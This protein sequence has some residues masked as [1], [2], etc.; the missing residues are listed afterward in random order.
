[1][2]DFDKNLL[3]FLES[4]QEQNRPI[5]LVTGVFDLLHSGH[6]IFLQKAKQKMRQL[7][8]YLLVGLESDFRV[9][10]LKGN[11]R[12]INNQQVRKKELADLGLV[13]LV[14]LLPDEFGQ[15]QVR[16]D[17]LK[18]IKPT[19][20]LVSSSTPNI[21]KKVQMIEKVGGKLKIIC[22]HYPQYSTTNIINKSNTQ[23]VLK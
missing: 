22:D 9:K 2:I 16:A 11:D 18:L 20:L 19:L 15:E 14:F 10:R 6:L 1:M 7:G 17:L 8:G 12:P 21:N 3:H 23:P 13:D 4:H 5:G